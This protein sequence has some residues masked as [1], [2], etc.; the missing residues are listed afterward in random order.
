MVSRM[1]VNQ[2]YG[3]L[4]RIGS[5]AAAC[6]LA[7]NPAFAEDEDM[8]AD[9]A[10]AVVIVNQAQPVLPGGQ[11]QQF[12]AQFEPL[13]KVELSLINRACKPSDAE[14][15]VLIAKCNR[16]LDTFIG[17]YAKRGGQPQVEGMWFGGPVGNMPNPRES[18]AEGLKPVVEKLLSKDQFQRYEDECRRRAEFEKAVAVENLV[19]KIDGELML[20]PQQREKLTE[21]L[22][23]NWQSSW[24]PQIE[25]FTV[26]V[27][28]WP[29]V[30]DQWIR[31]HLTA[32][33]Q[34]AW[35]RLN[36]QSVQGF[37]GGNVF[38]MQGQV[39]DD[40]DLNEGRDTPDNNDAEQGVGAANEPRARPIVRL[41]PA[42]R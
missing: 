30:P 15:K 23:S 36:K 37:F 7:A 32:A 8:F 41:R 13:L 1:P 31:P 28:M 25:M 10:D 18:F 20:S 17:D 16:W 3:L 22:S 5:C 27:D 40:I 29:N 24:A 33:Q 42:Q 12:R 14:R 21:S 35:S 11:L 4:S 9:V 2:K 19:A 38:G 34:A 26:G 6:L 39:I